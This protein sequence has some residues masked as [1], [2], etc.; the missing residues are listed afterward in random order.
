MSAKDTIRDLEFAA[1]L[2]RRK[3]F[4]VLVQVTNRCNMTC[5]FCDFWPNP[6]PKSEELT[7]KD[8]ARISDELRELG[9][10]L[11]SI[12]GGEPLARNDLTDIVRA[13]GKHHLPVLFTNGW[14]VTRDIAREL[15]DAGLAHANVSI[16][17]ATAKRHDDKRGQDGAT[18][19]AWQAIDHFLATA[20]HG[21]RGHQVH[22][23]TVFMKDNQGEMGTLF[24]QSKARGVGHQV[25]L[26][27]LG[28]AR[29]GKN[30]PDA[31]PDPDAARAL[32]ALVKKTPHVRFFR[33]YFDEVAA[34]LR[35]TEFH[36]CR[37]GVDTFNIDHVGNVSPCIEKIDQSVGS[38]KTDRLSTL[39]ARLADAN[40]KLATCNDCF[41]ACRGFSHA[42]GAGR[43]AA[44][45]IDL[46]TRMRRA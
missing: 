26:L 22:V 9:C 4:Q 16:D 42:L 25:T 13:F 11:V 17:Y 19:R 14:L 6:A 33:S 27:S 23:M 5:S 37:A 30:G 10:F 34:F 28:G 40:Q 44:N 39:Y 46:G 35:G 41:T 31:L 29:R 38:V 1:G 21:A 24:D 7:A 45:L 32:A 20:P 2:A 36:G 3:P 43:S 18:E 12:E 15:W 8:Y